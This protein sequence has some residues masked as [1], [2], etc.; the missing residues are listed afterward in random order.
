MNAP[1]PPRRKPPARRWALWA[2]VPLA[3]LAGHV[4]L[5]VV[6]MALATGKNGPVIDPAYYQENKPLAVQPSEPARSAEDR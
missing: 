4:T 3:L 1:Y 6:A 5:M 2:L